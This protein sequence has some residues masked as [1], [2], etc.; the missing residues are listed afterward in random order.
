MYTVDFFRRYAQSFNFCPIKS[1]DEVLYEEH[2]IFKSIEGA[3][4]LVVGGGPT[5]NSVQWGSQYDLIFSCNHFFLNNKLKDIKVDF[6]YLSYE[7]DF[8]RTEFKQYLDKFDTV[9]CFENFAW[10]YTKD[11]VNQFNQTYP[12]RSLQLRLRYDSKLGAGAR[13]LVM[14]TLFKPQSIDFVGIDGYNKEQCKL[15]G[16]PL[17]SFESGKCNTTSYP[18]ELFDKQFSELATYLKSTNIP[19]NNLGHGHEYNM[20]TRYL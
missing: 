7:C 6:A 4:I 5:T 2:P 11:R 13:L 12:G 3:K 8:Y 15:G 19:I 9:F 14:T 17:H 16:N 10:D 1:N 18:F 20:L